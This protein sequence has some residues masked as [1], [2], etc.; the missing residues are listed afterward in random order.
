MLTRSEDRSVYN[1]YYR[2]DKRHGAGVMEYGNGAIYIGEWTHNLRSGKGRME[3]DHKVI[4]GN[5]KNNDF[6]LPCAVDLD[7]IMKP[8]YQKDVPRNMEAYLKKKAYFPCEVRIPNLE[9]NEILKPCLVEILKDKCSKGL[10]KGHIYRKL[11]YLLKDKTALRDISIQIHKAFSNAPNNSEILEIFR[12]QIP[13]ELEKGETSIKWYGINFND[14]KEPE[15]TLPHMIISNDCI[16]GQGVEEHT[17]YNYTIDGLCGDNGMLDIYLKIGGEAKK[18]NC[19]AGPNYLTGID[20][21]ENKF[22][23]I[24][25]LRMWKGFFV[26]EDPTNK[27]VIKYFLKIDKQIVY[28]FGR[29]STGIYMISGKAEQ[30]KEEDPDRRSHVSFTV[31]YSAGYLISFVGRID[32]LNEMVTG[33]DC[34]EETGRPARSKASSC[35]D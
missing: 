12:E 14:K 3:K 4:S 1:G 28:G 30:P 17:G 27:R 33:S 25:D 16:F 13:K 20:N 10:I 31:Y 29:D 21:K 32:K 23:M 2:D 5:Y 19:I 8:I 9:L 35:S 26:E 6:Q 11:R 18:L 7:E 24:P 34:S 15:F 22:I